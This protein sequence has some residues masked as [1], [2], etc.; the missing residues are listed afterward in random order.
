MTRKVK[1]R[2]QKGGKVRSCSSGI[3]NEKGAK[4]SMR[5]T[6]RRQMKRKLCFQDEY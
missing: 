3:E 6:H 1:E 5:Q 4:R 2:N